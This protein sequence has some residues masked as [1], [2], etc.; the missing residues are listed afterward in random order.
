MD[1][2]K[3]TIL[4]ASYAA[5]IST[6]VAIKEV[7]DF[8]S[9]KKDKRRAYFKKISEHIGSLSYSSSQD[10]ITNII[11]NINRIFDYDIDPIKKISSNSGY[12]DFKTELIDDLELIKYNLSLKDDYKQDIFYNEKNETIDKCRNYSKNV[13]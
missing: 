8:F 11:D 6:V 3:L 9:S 7:A 5:I 1:S 2:S 13:I 10:D 4:V 12:T